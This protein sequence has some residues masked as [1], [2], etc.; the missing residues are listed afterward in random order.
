MRTRLMTVVASSRPVRAFTTATPVRTSCS[1]ALRRRSIPRASAT[2]AGLPRTSPPTTTT[3]SAPRM[4]PSP[5]RAA[6]ARALSRARRATACGKGPGDRVSSMS[7]GTT[8]N[9]EQRELSNSRRLGEA[10]AR[11]RIATPL[12]DDQG[13]GIVHDASLRVDGRPDVL[14]EVE[15]VLMGVAVPVRQLALDAVRDEPVDR[16]AVLLEGI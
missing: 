1:L 9:S 14:G 5:R 11:T 10:E 16:G 8:W 13:V 7:A 3:V 15:G 12:R 2:S 6:T 4:T